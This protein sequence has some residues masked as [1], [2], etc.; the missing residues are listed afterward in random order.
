MYVCEECNE[1]TNKLYNYKDKKICKGC[2][3]ILDFFRIFFHDKSIK[4]FI[5]IFKINEKL[6]RNILIVDVFNKDFR[7]LI[8][9]VKIN[10]VYEAW[11]DAILFCAEMITDFEFTKIYI[12]NKVIINHLEGTFKPRQRNL[13]KYFFDLG[14]YISK[15]LQIKFI[16]PEHNFARLNPYNFIYFKIFQNYDRSM[17]YLDKNEKHFLDDDKQDIEEEGDNKNES[18]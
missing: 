18:A 7:I 16:E 17:R 9:E 10:D 5:D 2:Y 6:F 8:R 4:V 13:K 14:K 1:T 12:N 11:Y 3:E 15:G